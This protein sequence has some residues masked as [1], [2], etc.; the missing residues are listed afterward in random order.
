MERDQ[1]ASNERRRGVA[2]L[3]SAYVGVRNPEGDRADGVILENGS[4]SSVYCVSIKSV[5]HGGQEDYPISLTIVPPGKYFIAR[6]G[7]AYHWK[8]PQG[9]EY[10][11]EEVRPIMK[12]QVWRVTE[13]IFTDAA[14]VSWRRDEHGVLAEIAQRAP[15]G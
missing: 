8:F 12:T 15:T 9:V 7:D 5:K 13:M 3:V 1:V 4:T 11:S 14:G 2:D 10:L 6:S